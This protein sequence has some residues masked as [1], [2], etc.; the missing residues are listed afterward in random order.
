MPLLCN[1]HAE[2]SAFVLVLE[3]PYFSVTEK[4][5]VFKIDNVPPG[6]YK[7]SAWHEK[8][9]TVTQDV[10]VEAGKTSNVDYNLKKK[11]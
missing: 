4:D 5:G 10:T 1:V 8:L 11:K 9:R 3:N 6:T 2:M 7:V